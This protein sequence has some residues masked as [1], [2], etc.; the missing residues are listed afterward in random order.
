MPLLPLA[1]PKVRVAL[2]AGQDVARRPFLPVR[3]RVRADDSAVG[4]DHARAERGHRHR[5]AIAVHIQHCLVVAQLADDPQRPHA[6]TDLP[7][8]AGHKSLN[9]FAARY[10]VYAAISFWASDFVNGLVGSALT[11]HH[12][13]SGCSRVSSSKSG[14]L[15]FG[16]EIFG[17][18][19]R[20]FS[21]F[22]HPALV[23]LI[24]GLAPKMTAAG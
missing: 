4:A 3:S 24:S 2:P 13:P 12:P 16:A 1:C 20:C 18:A 17:W 6:A 15:I 10:T 8:R 7:T 9:S 21:M 14:S 19:I 22:I 11:T 23:T 5:I